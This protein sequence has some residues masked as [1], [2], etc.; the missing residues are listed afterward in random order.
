MLPIR[1]LTGETVLVNNITQLK[2]SKKVNGEKVLTFLAVP[3]ERNEDSWE[4]VQNESIVAFDGHEYII[5]S[6]QEKS[7]GNRSIKHIEAVQTF[8]NTLINS[9]MYES[10]SGSQ[11]FFES[12]TRVFDRTPFDFVIVGSFTAKTFENFG[13]D[14]KLSLF[15]NI[16]ER[17]AA[18]FELV[19]S[20]VYLKEEI[21]NMT[22][23]Q[24]RWKYN[25]K[26][27]S[28][29][30]DTKGLATVIKGFGGQPDEETG[31]YPLVR[32]Y[33]SNVEIFGELHAEAVFDERITN[34]DTMDAR[35]QRELMDEP[36]LSITVD[37]TELRDSNGNPL[38][39]INE[40]DKGFII[41]EPMNITVEARVVEVDEEFK[42]ISGEWVKVKTNVTLSNLKK[43]LTDKTTRFDQTAKRVDRLFNGQEGLPYN[44][45][46]EAVR[47]AAEAINNSLTEIQYPPGQGIVLQDPTDPNRLV[48]LT[49]AGI[50]LSDDGGATYRTAMTGAGIVTNELVAGIIRTNNIQIVGEDD[51]FF[52]DGTGLYAYNPSDLTKYVRLNSNG[53]YIAKGA[54]TIERPDGYPIVNNGLS[55]YDLNIQSHDPPFNS[56]S[57]EHVGYFWRTN[58]EIT[59]DCNFY[60]FEHKSRYLKLGLVFYAQAGGTCTVTIERGSVG[61]GN[62]E[63][64]ATVSTTSTDPLNATTVT[65]DLGV[66]TGNRDSI[67]IRVKTS[68]AAYYAYVRSPRRWLEG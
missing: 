12:L 10:F 24:L 8:F 50:G 38:E 34:P 16:L 2:R 43:R 30:I 36:Q 47:I 11:T 53:L 13:Q 68:N 49:S 58:S 3:D 54:I 42:F 46:P 1:N 65:V 4:Y 55:V 35:L 31:L 66:P 40:G 18:E 37:F 23:F 39:V 9:Y 22:G 19:G 48:R 14:N 27:I 33:R 44:V 17:F 26:A 61:M 52:W 51:L 15:Q 59:Q 64:L 45:L 62:N 28:K 5:K 56:S 29:D 67:Y 7:I 25:I 6:N 57:V 21:G 41:Y 32:E 20:T 60:T 63:V